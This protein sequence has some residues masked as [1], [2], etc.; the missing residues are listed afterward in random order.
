MRSRDKGRDNA[1][2]AARV[3]EIPRFSGRQGARRRL[4]QPGC[5]LRGPEGTGYSARRMGIH[6]RHILDRLVGPHGVGPTET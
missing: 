2:T 5:G 6:G 1:V 3:A 4:A